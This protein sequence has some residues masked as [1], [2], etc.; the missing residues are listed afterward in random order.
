M[1]TFTVHVYDFEDPKGSRFTASSREQA[2]DIADELVQF[3][4]F[5]EQEDG[6]LR[7]LG[8]NTPYDVAY[9]SDPD[10]NLIYTSTFQENPILVDPVVFPM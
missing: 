8:R 4:E 3:G 9:V 6:V 1:R 5:V 2:M 10:N 7:I